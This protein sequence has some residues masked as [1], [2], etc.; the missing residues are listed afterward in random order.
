MAALVA[1]EYNPLSAAQLLLETQERDDR[2]HKEQLALT[3]A[4]STGGKKRS[5]KKASQQHRKRTTRILQQQQQAGAEIS[6]GSTCANR[7]A[8]K[9]GRATWGAPEDEGGL[10]DREEEEGDEGLSSDEYRTR[11]DA[12]AMEMKVCFQKAAEAFTRG[13]R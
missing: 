4:G 2:R 7:R 11:A 6:L 3:S 8:G 1:T 5:N 10:D 13:G 9:G 12:A